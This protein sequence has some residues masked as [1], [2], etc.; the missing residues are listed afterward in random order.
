MRVN[1]IVEALKVVATELWH[2][3]SNVIVSD[4]HGLIVIVATAAETKFELALFK[5][6]AYHDAAMLT[7]YK[8][9]LK[10]QAVLATVRYLTKSEPD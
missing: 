4:W 5:F 6:G 3:D 9:G 8:V 10:P 1:E 2:V 7:T